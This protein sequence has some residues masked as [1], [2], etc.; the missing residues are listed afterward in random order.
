MAH[1]AFAAGAATVNFIPRYLTEQLQ[2]LAATTQAPNSTN[3]ELAQSESIRT[4]MGEVNGRRFD[5]RVAEDSPDS[6]QKPDNGKP[7]TPRRA[8]AST[9][10]PAADGIVSSIQG[11]ILAVRATPGQLVE[12]GQVLFIV[13][14][15]KMENEITAPHAGTLAEV[16]ATLGQVVEAGMVLATYAT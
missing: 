4:F 16:R 13:E 6:L 8:V 12:A 7:R 11:A 1:P 3:G 15:M 10:R 9:H 5:V 14:A 2:A